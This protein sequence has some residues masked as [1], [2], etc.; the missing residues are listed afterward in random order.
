MGSSMLRSTDTWKAPNSWLEFL[1][2]RIK[3]TKIWNA[4]KFRFY[5]PL[6]LVKRTLKAKLWTGQKWLWTSIF[7]H[8]NRKNPTN[9]LKCR[10][11]KSPSLKKSGSKECAPKFLLANA[12]WTLFRWNLQ[13]CQQALLQIWCQFWPATIKI[14]HMSFRWS[15]LIA[16]ELTIRTNKWFYTPGNKGQIWTNI[17]KISKSYWQNPKKWGK[18]QK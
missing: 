9:S 14:T 18:I 4:P 13:F 8:Q 5:R 11:N 12:F 3:S 15:L 17:L 1:K 10:K 6:W 2:S 7:W 16:W